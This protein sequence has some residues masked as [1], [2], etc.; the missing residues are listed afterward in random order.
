MSAADPASRR[1]R[2]FVPVVL[3]GLGASVVT[4]VAGHQ[5][6]LQVSASDLSRFGMSSFAGE[7]QAEAGFPLAGA[8][9]LVALACWGVVLVARGRF[10]QVVAVLA[11]LAAGGVLAV[12]VVGGFVQDDEAAVAISEQIGASLLGDRLPLEYTVWFWL[13]TVASVVAVAAA[14]AGALSSPDWPE[15]GSRYDAPATHEQ[16]DSEAPPE[17]RTSLDLWKSMD[18]GDDPTDQ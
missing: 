1:R 5:P 16:K 18:Q 6:M 17:E 13:A 2:T 14:V 10:R 12:Q 15:M 11:A 9:A 4:A 3:V 7:E 8:L